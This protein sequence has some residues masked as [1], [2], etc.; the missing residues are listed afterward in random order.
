MVIGED[1]H[2]KGLSGARR[3]KLYLEGTMRISGAFANTDSPACARK[4]TRKWPHG[5]QTF[6][7]D[8]G[9]SMRGEPFHANQ[10]CAEVKN[11]RNGSDQGT[12]FSEFLA[13]C[14]VAQKGDYLFGDHYMWITWAP[15]SAKSWSQLCSSEKVT[16][17]VIRHRDRIFGSISEQSARLRVDA[18]IAKDVAS[19]TWLIVLSEKQEQLLPLAEWRG[20]VAHELTLRGEW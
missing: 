5:G 20:I 10:F 1:A 17:G 11:Y 9:G 18:S 19:R 6:S 14:Y 2:L 13:K 16:E 8:L 12:H 4:L 7:F 15:F 3:A